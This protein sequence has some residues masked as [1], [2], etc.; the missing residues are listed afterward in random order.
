MLTAVLP[1]TP[2]RLADRFE[3]TAVM[4]LYVWLMM[5]LWPDTWTAADW[6]PLLILFSEGLVVIFLLIRRPTD[7]ISMRWRDWALA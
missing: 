1:K 6:Y 5:R 3:Q 7:Q 2:E 4:A